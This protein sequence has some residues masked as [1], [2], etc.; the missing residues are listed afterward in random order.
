MPSLDNSLVRVSVVAI[1]ATVGFFS[2][3]AA[4]ISLRLSGK[5]RGY[6]TVL[7][8]IDKETAD[9][10]RHNTVHLLIF[11]RWRFAPSV[12]PLCTKLETFLRLAKVPYEAHVITSTAVSPNE[13]LPCIVHNNRRMVESNAII[14]YITAQFHVQLDKSLTEEQRAI[15]T[16]VASMLE[17]GD[18]FAYYRTVTGDGSRVLI[19]YFAHAWHVPRLFARLIFRRMRLHLSHSLQIAGMS[20]SREEYEFE[21]LQD[22]KAI[23]H[24]IG[25]KAFL[26]GSQPSSF[27]CAVYAA[28]LPIVS[29]NEVEKVSKPFAYVKHSRILTGYVNRMTQAAF[30]DLSKLLEGQ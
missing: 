12:S 9:S 2:L 17:Y 30:P 8:A 15:G 24:I 25:E 7:A 14:N 16:A 26:L 6:R 28:F 1:A 3:L 4:A 11:S 29:M 21:Y 22:I 13:Y 23:E 5:Q 27:D 18:Q 19:P 10:D 20:T